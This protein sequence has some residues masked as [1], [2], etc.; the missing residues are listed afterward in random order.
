MY[1][2]PITIVYIP[3][4]RLPTSKRLSRLYH[5]ITRQV[6]AFTVRKGHPPKT[7]VVGLWYRGRGR[8]DIGNG[9]RGTEGMEEPRSGSTACQP[10]L[11]YA[12][13]MII[14]IDPCFGSRILILIAPYCRRSRSRALHDL[15]T[16]RQHSPRICRRILVAPIMD[17]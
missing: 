4:G 15:A 3:I 12:V 17:D 7:W 8:V 9:T 2:D 10:Q 16:P 6:R 5:S 13:C 1:R 11:A 14:S